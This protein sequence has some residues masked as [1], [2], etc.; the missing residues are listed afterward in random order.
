MDELKEHQQ[1]LTLL[2]EKLSEQVTS[3]SGRIRHGS[4]QAVF[5]MQLREID[6]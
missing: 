3:P 6:L 2:I 4:T 1:Y 5:A